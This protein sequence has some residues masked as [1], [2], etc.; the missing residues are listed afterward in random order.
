MNPLQTKQT[1][2]AALKP[3]SPRQ[4][5]E[6]VLLAREAFSVEFPPTDEDFNVW[7]HRNCMQA[8]E[9]P[10]LTACRNEDYL[11]LR[12]HFLA[13]CG[14]TLEAESARLRHETEPR[15]WALHKLADECR[16]AADV[17]PDAWRY[18]AGFVQHKRGVAIDDADEKTVWH[19]VYVVRRRAEQ[20][21]RKG[22]AA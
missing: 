17:L 6:L 7:R 20:L 8:V 22:V 19:A 3:L 15:T 13:L 14:R 16:E 18:A 5:R 1:S 4:V 10:G 21:R 9:R 11:P 2:G 12:T